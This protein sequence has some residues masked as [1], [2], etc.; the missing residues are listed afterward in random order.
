[1]CSTSRRL[2]VRRFAGI[3]AARAMLV[4][5]R[6]MPVVAPASCMN[7]RRSM[8]VIRIRSPVA[9]EV[10]RG[11][12]G[13]LFRPADAHNGA[14]EK[15]QKSLAEPLDAVFMAG[16]ALT[17]RYARRRCDAVPLRRCDAR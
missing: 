7:L 14:W 3:S 17:W 16:D 9:S 1:M 12:R 6:D 13:S 8:D 15:R 5:S 4:D 2:P 11:D 10:E